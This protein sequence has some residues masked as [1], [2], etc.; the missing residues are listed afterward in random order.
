MADAVQSEIS[1]PAAIPSKVASSRWLASR[2]CI[3]LEALYNGVMSE[4]EIAALH[5]QFEFAH[6]FD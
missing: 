3:G 4:D 1:R 2:P 6:G 5:L